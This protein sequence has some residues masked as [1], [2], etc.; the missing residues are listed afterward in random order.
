MGAVGDRLTGQA[1]GHNTTD[2]LIGVAGNTIDQSQTR[3]LLAQATRPAYVSPPPP[4]EAP[5]GEW[6][7]VPGQWINGQWVPAHKT[8]VPVNPGGSG[9]Q[10]STSPQETTPP[11]YSMQAP[12]S[13]VPIPGTYVYFV[14]DIGVDIL[15]Y[16]GYWYR[17]HAGH[18]YRA[19]AYN[20]PWV[21]IVPQTVPAV[22]IGLPPNYR[23]GIPPGYR[24]VRY[25]ELRRNWER[26]ERERHW[27]HYRGRW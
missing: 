7:E 24:P 16:H 15:F 21:Y 6:V 1:I 2:T 22:I 20:G 26:W 12:P 25:V 4:E 9:G 18:W 19:A 27:D 10:V 5:P 23:R 13:V 8:W 17:P 11:P 14:P 3:E